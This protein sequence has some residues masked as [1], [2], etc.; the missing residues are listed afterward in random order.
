MTSH[1]G[2]AAVLDLLQLGVGAV[3]AERVEGEAV[4]EARLRAQTVYSGFVGSVMGFSDVRHNLSPYAPV[5]HLKGT[6]DADTCPF[7]CRCGTSVWTTGQHDV[8]W[9]VTL[10]SPY[11]FRLDP[12]AAH[13]LELLPALVSL[14]LEVANDE[15]L[16]RGQRGVGHPVV[17]GSGV[18]P[19]TAKG[20]VSVFQRNQ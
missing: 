18:V 17:L 5:G 12:P 3:L 19:A 10:L 20:N 2:E 13:R 16:D 11:G 15:E 1:H 4:Q 8:S 14:E 9:G 6:N 7:G